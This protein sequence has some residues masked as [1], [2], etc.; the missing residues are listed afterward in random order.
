MGISESPDVAQEIMENVLRDCDCEV[1]IDDIGVFGNTWE[2]HVNKLDKVLTVLQNKGFT[3]NP[4]KCE[5]A[6]QET[7]WLG[8]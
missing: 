1:Y 3:I 7:D 5:W 2:E 4:L 6:I 8:H